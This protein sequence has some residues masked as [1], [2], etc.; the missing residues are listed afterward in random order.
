M[1]DKIQEKI[2]KY[3]I[4]EREAGNRAEF[5]MIGEFLG[6][7][8]KLLESAKEKKKACCAAKAATVAD[9]DDG[10][11]ER[12]IRVT[13]CNICP[14]VIDNGL[15]GGLHC[16][17]HPNL[18]IDYVDKINPRCDLDKTPTRQKEGV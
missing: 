5:N 9:V 11:E 18:W 10:V 15:P 17:R 13:S 6:D 7:L 16:K 3:E 2:D 12:W 1:I 14:H 4:L 8:G